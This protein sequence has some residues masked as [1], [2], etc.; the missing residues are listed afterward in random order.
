M[1]KKI[2]LL[3]VLSLIFSIFSIGINSLNISDN[4]DIQDGKSPKFFENF[5]VQNPEGINSANNISDEPE[6]QDQFIYALIKFDY[7]DIDL[8][9]LEG[10]DIVTRRD[11]VKEYYKEKNE[12][13][14]K[15]LGL[16]DIC[17]SYGAPY[18]DIIY[19]SM[20]DYKSGRDELIAV[21]NEDTIERID[22]DLL[23]ISDETTVADF[24]SPEYPL[25]DVF[26]D[27]GI[28]DNV[29]DGSGIKVGILEKGTPSDYTC[30]PPN[31]NMEVYSDDPIEYDPSKPA[32]HA[33]TVMS[34]LGC[35]SGVAKGV[36]FY[37]A[38]FNDLS[39]YPY[40]YNDDYSGKYSPV[41]CLNWLINTK[42][43][44][45]I[46]MSA[47]VMSQTSVSAKYTA[48]CAYVDAISMINSCIIVNSAGNDEY[49]HFITS[50]G[51]T[52]NTMVV[53]AI[54]KN[55]DVANFSSYIT[56]NENTVKP[57]VVAPGDNICDV[58]NL[59]NIGSGTSYA[60]PLVT[61][62][63]ARLMHEFPILKSNPSLLK[64]VL[65]SGAHKL[66]SAEGTGLDNESGAGIVNYAN[67][68][69]IMQNYNYASKENKSGYKKDTVLFENQFCVSPN[70]TVRINLA[71]IIPGGYDLL[72]TDDPFVP[73]TVTALSMKSYKVD[74]LYEYHGYTATLDSFTWDSS[75]KIAE[76]K[77]PF[78]TNSIFT[79]R[80][81]L[82]EDTT[83]LFGELISLSYSGASH[84]HS[85][86]FSY[87]SMGKERHSCN[88]SCGTVFEYEEHTFVG[89]TA[90][91]RRCSKCG[92][93][94]N[95]F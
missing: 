93:P 60:A 84:V 87:T 42:Y 45:I 48:F 81:T 24:D 62:I 28:T 49:Q 75:S 18:A 27:I 38:S 36:S 17:V 71:R 50:P 6:S 15:E 69:Y 59:G 65:M 34:L 30:V 90:G 43:V 11:T 4:Y 21:S 19:S 29:Y 70:S 85:C 1:K 56:V 61:G 57:E 52:V 74:I 8:H 26:T 2:S 9:S 54:N 16:E 41:G 32:N 95:L 82:L 92:M 3:L 83:S 80:I 58:P 53:G 89:E 78:L 51:M 86:D 88:C 10:M 22:V 91:Q 14:A 20:E 63:A 46:N 44:D 37:C 66:S 7:P 72:L 23:S 13:I 64:S 55:K 35:T 33:Y 68:R 39:K 47:C 67:S 79:V 76:Y 73:T 77:H 31:I 94:E 5:S 40:P 12:A 25:S